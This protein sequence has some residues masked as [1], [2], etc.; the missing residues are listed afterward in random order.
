MNLKNSLR[1]ILLLFVQYGLRTSAEEVLELANSHM[2]SPEGYM[3]LINI[4]AKGKK[5]QMC[6]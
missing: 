6:V 2:L 3:R 5:E 1:Y 4:N